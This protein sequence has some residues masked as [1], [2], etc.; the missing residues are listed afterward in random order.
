MRID[1]FRL[2]AAPLSVAAVV[3]AWFHFAATGDAQMVS[4][5]QRYAP[6]YV[7][8]SLG[9]PVG[10][11]LDNT[12]VAVEFNGTW[13][14]VPMAIDRLGDSRGMTLEYSTTDCTGTAYMGS[15]ATMAPEVPAN[16]IYA[17]YPSLPYETV[18]VKSGAG[19]DLATGIVGEC[20][21]ME[22]TGAYYRRARVADL[23]RFKPPFSVRR[24]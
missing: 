21:S 2:L 19:F 20:L 11:F 18:S 15:D 12:R 10:Q 24:P 9:Q 8:D 3:A 22:T 7:F 17:I 13:V 16:G 4:T 1:R 23:R 5:V 6:L 14:I